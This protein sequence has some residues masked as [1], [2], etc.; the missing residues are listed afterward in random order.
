[1]QNATHTIIVSTPEEL[2]PMI[3]E[4]V[5]AVEE[6]KADDVSPQG[7]GCFLQRMSNTSSAFTEKCWPNGARKASAGRTPHSADES[8]MN[9]QSSK[10]TSFPNESKLPGTLAYVD[11]MQAYLR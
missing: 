3:M 2:M 9:G 5:R 7:K 1:M 4:A 11:F 10:T 6:R 8:S